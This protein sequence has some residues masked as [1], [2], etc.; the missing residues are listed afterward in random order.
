M[1]A[2][3]ARLTL[4]ISIRNTRA[5]S[6]LLRINL[7]TITAYGRRTDVVGGGQKSGAYY[8]LDRDTGETVRGVQGGP[9]GQFGGIIGARRLTVS[10]STCPKATVAMSRPHWSRRG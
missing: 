5:V 2:S 8:T 7:F 3:A 10:A 4:A 9:G 1:S 6:G